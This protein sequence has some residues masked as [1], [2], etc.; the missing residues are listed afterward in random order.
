MYESR[1]GGVSLQVY[2]SVFH[3][4]RQITGL[5]Q[6]C[7]AGGGMK[8]RW[9]EGREGAIDGFTDALPALHLRGIQAVPAAYRA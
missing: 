1:A 3:A 9:Q 6:T 2:F 7:R 8:G 4:A 5:V